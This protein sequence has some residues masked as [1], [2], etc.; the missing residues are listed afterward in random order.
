[1]LVSSPSTLVEDLCSDFML[2]AVNGIAEKIPSVDRD[3]LAE[4]IQHYRGVC[5]ERIRHC[6]MV[7]DANCNSEERNT[8]E[9]TVRLFQ[10]SSRN[11]LHNVALQ[12]ARGRDI[13]LHETEN[14]KQYMGTQEFSEWLESDPL[15]GISI[16]DVDL[17]VAE[18]RDI[19]SKSEKFELVSSNDGLISEVIQGEESIDNSR[20]SRSFNLHTDGAYLDRVPD[21]VGLYC[22]DPGY[23]N[24]RTSFSNSS[25]AIETLSKKDQSILRQ[26]YNVFLARGGVE[27]IRPLIETHPSTMRLISNLTNRGTVKPYLDPKE[28]KQLG[29]FEFA[30]PLHHLIQSLEQGEQYEHEWKQNQLVLFDNLTYTHGRKAGNVGIDYQRYLQR[31]WIRRKAN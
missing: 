7:T 31:I 6:I 15:V 22:V 10:K 27:T 1:M 5:M 26:L 11:P 17:N 8:I 13:S 28:M 2:D 29:P 25:D 12:L 20:S 21:Y 19:L 14:Q 16:Q 24:A 3:T 23:G 18:L 30:E 4:K 9:D